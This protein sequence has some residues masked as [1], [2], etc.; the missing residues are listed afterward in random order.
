MFRKSLMVG[1]LV[2]VVSS[3]VV[4]AHEGQNGQK[5]DPKTRTEKLTKD[6]NLTPD[7]AA[8]IQAVLEAS[9]AQKEENSAKIDAVLTPE[10]R[11]KYDAMRDEHKK[12]WE[13]KKD[14]HHHEK[15]E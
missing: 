1:I 14:E 10:Q 13:K 4:Y 12:D 5:W 15:S 9:K 11:A 7:Q 6:L 2:L 3:G 8:K